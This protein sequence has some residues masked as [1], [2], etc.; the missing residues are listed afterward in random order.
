MT[1]KEPLSE[2]AILCVDDEYVVLASLKEQLKRAFGNKYLYEVAESA[3]EAWEI[4]EE[5][6]EDAINIV[7]IVSDWL[8]PGTKGDEFL[9]QVHKR[10]PNIVTVLLTGQADQQAIEKAQEKANLYRCLQ[11]PWAEDELIDTIE[12]GLNINNHSLEK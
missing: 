12:A 4:I 5:L 7:M 8:M 3:Y 6:Q 9:I 2:V 10:F 11:K 1:K